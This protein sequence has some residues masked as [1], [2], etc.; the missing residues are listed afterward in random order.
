MACCFPFGKDVLNH[1][2]NL[3]RFGFS[4][5]AGGIGRAI[6]SGL[7]VISLPPCSMPLFARQKGVWELISQNTSPIGGISSNKS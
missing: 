2:G 6:G 7:P 1:S 4:R 3:S 5:K